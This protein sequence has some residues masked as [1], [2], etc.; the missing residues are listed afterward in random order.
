MTETQRDASIGAGIGAVIG[1][2]AG[3]GKGAAIGTAIGAAGGYAWSKRMEHQRAEMDRAMANTGVVVSQTDD[4]RL[5]LN[6]PSNISFNTN[7]ASIKPEFAPLLDKLANSLNE[8]PDTRI[9]IAGHTDNTGSDAINNPLSLRRADSTRNYLHS[10]G[11]SLSR[12]QTEGHGSRQPIAS[13][14]TAQGRAQNRRVEIF[15]GEP[16]V[17][18]QKALPA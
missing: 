4:N 10:R 2:I 16:A 6:I 15:V 18:N 14:A 9:V 7:Q 8:N 12:I 17:N 13:N 11:V 1:A 3:D 5:K